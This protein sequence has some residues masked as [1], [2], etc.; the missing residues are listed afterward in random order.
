[1][2]HENAFLDKV[3]PEL[4]RLLG[5]FPAPEGVRP[6]VL[7]A[8]SG[9]A[10]STA[11]LLAAVAW[12]ER[13]GGPDHHDRPLAAVHVNHR[14]RGE[15]SDRDETFCA[16]LCLGLDVPLH[17]RR[18]EPGADGSE[19]AA[20]R[21]RRRI[22]AELLDAH[23]DLA[24]C[25]TAHHRDDQLE[26][27][28]MRFFRGAGAEG[29]RGIRPVAGRIIHPLLGVGHAEIEAFLEA[30][31]Q[32]WRTDPTNTD[33]SNT[34][35][36]VRTEL[37]PLARDIFGPAADTAPARLAKLL[38]SD[39]AVL[40]TIARGLLAGL[41]ADGDGTSLPVADLTTL[42]P[43]VSSRV[44]R[45]YL[46]DH[47]GV[48]TDLAR[49]HV[50]RLLDWLPG[51]RS[52]RGIDLIGGWRAFREFDRLVFVAPDG[53]P[54]PPQPRLEVRAASA[55]EI[56]V[57]EAEARQQQRLTLPADVLRGEPRL[58]SWRPGD[59]LT[60]FG[61]DGHK[62]ISDLL[63]EAGVPARL[64]RMYVL[65]EDDEGPFWLI[66]VSRA[67]RTRMLPSTATAVTLLIHGWRPDG[68][69]GE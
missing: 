40:E 5:R 8:L 2:T 22:Y 46:R 62:K 32:D 31:G 18:T 12:R 19:D 56:A 20:R 52:G 29:M 54:P 66:G 43:P 59:R 57:P 3:I 38:T 4:D 45:L 49:V 55:E 60:P 13:D 16:G 35:S 63:R 23:P 21:R 53:P 42:A 61:M 27:L 39:T 17:V 67:E 41:L 48:E 36:R 65:V 24:A 58:R 28:V 6:G 68:A 10:D 1:M 7:V 44:V 26:T 34:R 51:S 14:L 15:A 33:G 9:G 50:E 11:L 64:R 30:R 69:E 47:C 25:A 37:L